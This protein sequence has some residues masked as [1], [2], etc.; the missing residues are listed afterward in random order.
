MFAYCTGR[1]VSLFLARRKHIELKAADIKPGM[2]YVIAA[3]HQTYLDPWMSLSLIPLSLWKKLGMPRALV[4]NRF[5]S[6]PLVGSYLRSMGSFPAKVHPTDP[7]GLEYA[8]QLLD[9]GQ[10]I[11]IFPEGH[12]TLQR[13]NPARR[14][15][16][17]LAQQPN[18]RV[19]P[20]HFEWARP[21]I[22]S[23]FNVGIGKPFDGSKMTAQQILD[24]VYSI[25]VK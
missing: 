6:Y 22:R 14:G 1:F 25:P 3:N 24:A 21:R 15:V 13:Q 7:Y 17:V 10:S 19:I 20:M 11:V 9:R 2:R 23:N 8:T 12:V 5:F 4:V 16:M 18:V